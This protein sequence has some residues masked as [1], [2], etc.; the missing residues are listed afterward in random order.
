MVRADRTRADV[1]PPSGLKPLTSYKLA[2]RY[3]E[4]MTDEKRVAELRNGSRATPTRSPTAA[5]CEPSCAGLTRASIEK[6]LLRSR[7]I[8][9]S[10]PAMTADGATARRRSP[11]C[12]AD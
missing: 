9:G 3:R 1:T 8:A 12:R 4:F 2:I 10:S 7:W 6:M 11:A 5:A